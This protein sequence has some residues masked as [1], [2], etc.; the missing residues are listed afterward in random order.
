MHAGP[1]P[2]SV[3]GAGPDSRPSTHHGG[4]G[5]HTP[6]RSEH[7]GDA[8][9]S[10]TGES[11]TG[12]GA[13]ADEQQEPEVV[14]DMPPS[15][16]P[17][18]SITRDVY[19][20]RCPKVRRCWRRWL[21]SAGAT[22]A[23]AVQRSVRMAS[24]CSVQ[25]SALVDL[26]PAPH[27]PPPFRAPRWCSTGAASTRCL[28]CLASARGG[29]GWWSVSRATRTTPARWWQRCARAMPLLA[30]WL[31]MGQAAGMAERRWGQGTD[32]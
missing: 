6:P 15:W 19:D 14:P 28:L 9:S 2:L 12:G 4:D 21:F 17:K 10:Y 13:A 30:C 25:C 23:R 16:V 31:M 8:A 3:G 20:M 24:W 7:G 27:A 22:A 26:Q 11:Q 32:R 1:V 18:L 29:T 5:F